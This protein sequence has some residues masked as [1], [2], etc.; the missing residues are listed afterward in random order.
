MAGL[1]FPAVWGRRFG[2][3]PDGPWQCHGDECLEHNYPL[4]AGAVGRMVLVVGHR[5]RT[6]APRAA[7][8]TGMVLLQVGM[9]PPLLRMD[10]A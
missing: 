8:Y 3:I 6:D 10:V 7:W 2:S 9:V 1:V 5:D 4:Q